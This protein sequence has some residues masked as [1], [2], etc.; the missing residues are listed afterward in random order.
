[1]A[2][3]QWSTRHVVAVAAFLGLLFP[4]VPLGPGVSPAAAAAGT[5]TITVVASGGTSVGTDWTFDAGT[6]VITTVDGDPANIDG[7]VLETYLGTGAVTVEASEIVV[8][9][10]VEW[11][12]S[13][14]LTLKS[15]TNITVKPNKT[16]ISSSTADV[17]VW[18]DSDGTGNASTAGGFIRMEPATTG[19]TKIA[20]AGGQI[21]LG[22]GLASTSGIPNGE[23]FGAAS[24][25]T[26]VSV[27]FDTP[28]STGTAAVFLNNAVLAAGSGSVTIRGNGTGSG[29]NYQMG[30]WLHNSEVSAR[31][32]TIEGK[33]SENGLNNAYGILLA[34]SSITS[35]GKIS[36]DGRGG[37]STSGTGGDHHTGVLL[38]ES[39]DGSGSSLVGTGSGELELV[40]RGGRTT[41]NSGHGVFI[42]PKSSVTTGSGPIS[43]LGTTGEGSTGFG[44]AIQ[45]PP[46]SSSGNISIVGNLDSTSRVGSGKVEIIREAGETRDLETSTSIGIIALESP[47]S[48][49]VGLPITSAQLGLRGAGTFT[50]TN[51]ANQIGTVAAGTNAAPIGN[52][53][54]VDASGG[55]TIGQVGALE[56]INSSGTVTV[57]TT[58]GDITLARSISTT[59]TSASAITLNA[60]KSKIEEQDSDGD[61]IVSGA[62]NVRAGDGPNARVL[63]FSGSEA[64]STGLTTLVGG[65][66]NVRYGLDEDPAPSLTAGTYAL[67]R[68][69]VES[70]PEENDSSGG[71]SGGSS[72]SGTSRAK[73]SPV[74]ETPPPVAAPRVAPRPAPAINTDPVSKPVERRG[75]VF[76][77]NA[78]A[79]A[80]VGGA[81]ANLEKDPVGDTGLSVKAGAFQFDVSVEEAEGARV[82]TDTPSRSPELFVPRGQQTRLTGGGSYPGS[83]VQLWLPGNGSAGREIAR[84]P[85]NS[86]GTFSSSVG[87]DAGQLDGP[88]PIG[89]QVL[90]VVGYDESGNQTVVDMTI[91]I[92]QGVPSPEPNRESGELPALSFGQSL[93]TSAGMPQPVTVTGFSDMRRAVVEGPDWLISVDADRS[94]GVDQDGSGNVLVRL[95]PSSIGTA[96]GSG[97]LPGTVASVWLFSD[98]TLVATVTVDDNGE[99]VSEFLVDASV[100]PA[101][102]HTL[103]VQGVGQ[104][105]Y[106]KAANLGVLVEQAVASTEKRANTL[107][108]W[109]LALFALFLLLALVVVFALRRRRRES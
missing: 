61:I 22:G 5:G 95:T 2:H 60:G 69:S 77:P 37:R 67:Y 49:S 11:S 7:S 90:Q 18:A 9:D 43:I 1:M 41:S 102:E 28:G 50:L 84:I 97:F 46:Y 14:R 79:R 71:S 75:V 52:L 6:R 40:G 58:V 12:T 80:T 66:A 13:N 98:P 74:A 20:S 96:S 59:N 105:G 35:D 93:A 104:D 33:G 24:T 34:G 8:N 64:R 82:E 101:G 85:V 15:A 99:F 31:S 29:A 70:P 17:I 81:I 89:R 92:G 47:T 25:L 3:T 16:V 19:E 23:V 45:T 56:G 39:S 10:S 30:V 32:V 86:D 106:I 83:F 108:W 103:Q 87:F 68:S 21:V 36:L 51:S 65:S 73:S 27:R 38:S 54:L 94:G 53:S 91:N 42:R 55:L 100:I 63:L 88:V 107:L 78:P 109:V 76:D 57:E 26:S 72:S 44:A 62:P 4:L 48:T